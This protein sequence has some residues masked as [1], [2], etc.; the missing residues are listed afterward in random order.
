MTIQADKAYGELTLE[1]NWFY[2]LL[3]SKKKPSPTPVVEAVENLS[4]ELRKAGI[5]SDV[6]RISDLVR[7]KVAFRNVKQIQAILKEVSDSMGKTVSG[8]MSETTSHSTN[9]TTAPKSTTFYRLL[10]SIL[11]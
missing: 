4:S 8:S 2:E 3:Y 10:N 1:L 9:K 11:R 7:S 5:S 6:N